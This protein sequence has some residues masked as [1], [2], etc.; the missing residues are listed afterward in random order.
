MKHK[1][2]LHF[3]AANYAWSGEPKAKP[4]KSL[5]EQVA[6]AFKRA[7]A[8]AISTDPNPPVGKLMLAKMRESA[9]TSQRSIRRF[10]K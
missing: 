8:V 6:T 1:L 5:F 9:E 2:N 7:K 4:N 10:G 3:M